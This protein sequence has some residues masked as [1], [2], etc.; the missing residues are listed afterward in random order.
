M[1]EELKAQ[2]KAA[3]DSVVKSDAPKKLV[4]AG[5]GAG[6]TF[7]FQELL[8]AN[9]GE[10]NERLVLTFI[11]NLKDDLER[12]LE[13]LAQVYT[14]HGY[15]RR[16][17]HRNP[18]LRGTLTEG[19]HYYPPLPSLIS[20][21]WV[22]AHEEPTPKFI[23]LMRDLG[24]SEDLAFYLARADYYDAVSFDDSVFRVYAGFQAH[25][26]EVDQYQLLLVDEYQD[27][28]RLEVE[29]IR[30][31]AAG[32]STVI[33]GDDDQALY[34]QL[35][36]SNPAYIRELHRG[37]EY[38]H[39]SLPFC[40]RCTRPIVAAVGDIVRRAQALGRLRD[41]IDK[42]YEFYPPKKEN[43][44]VRYPRIRVVETSV[45]RN[46]GAN[47]FGR[48]IEQQLQRIPEDEIRESE[49]GNFPTV[50]IIGPQQYLRQIKDHLE[51][52]G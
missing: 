13:G 1:Y 35:R 48:Y 38:Q 23:G 39:F 36:S 3:V 20:S 43:D 21:D 22:I 17:L 46:N 50:L 41:R 26:R 30:T 29:F 24:E 27:F 14:F 12:T 45:Q 42:P 49:E 8:G 51:T 40:M 34:S 28:N 33:A 44:T 5:P 52:A 2:L 11:N 31:L 19:F 16:L 37:G 10:Q 25:P 15:C 4:V 7:L 18:R 9:E 6:K 32:S 47:Y